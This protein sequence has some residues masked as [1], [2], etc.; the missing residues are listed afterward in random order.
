MF[1]YAPTSSSADRL[2]LVP[3][4]FFCLEGFWSPSRLLV[5]VRQLLIIVAAPAGG[6]WRDG[7]FDGPIRVQYGVD[8]DPGVQ[9][10]HSPGFVRVR[11]FLH[12]C[13]SMY[14][15]VDAR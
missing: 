14:S 2:E 13:R 1:R 9:M 3:P 8:F 7:L 15:G 4:I 5:R 10:R 11:I 12:H 6:L